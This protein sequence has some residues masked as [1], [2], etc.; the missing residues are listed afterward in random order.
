[1]TIDQVQQT[2]RRSRASILSFMSI[3]IMKPLILPLIPNASIQSIAKAVVNRC[4][5]IPM[6]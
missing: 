5:F 4:C 3:P 6:K 2:L 1:M